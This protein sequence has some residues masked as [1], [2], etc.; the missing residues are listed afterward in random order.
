MLRRQGAGM[1]GKRRV[2]SASRGEAAVWAVPEG[3]PDLSAPRR[4]ARLLKEGREL[5]L[6]IPRLNVRNLCSMFYPGHCPLNAS[7]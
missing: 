7:F 4:P 2:K 3:S 5:T 6:R 1:P